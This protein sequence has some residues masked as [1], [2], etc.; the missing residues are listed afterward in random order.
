MD[1]TH[2]ASVIVVDVM[3]VDRV[4]LRSQEI[5]TIESRAAKASTN[6]SNRNRVNE[7][8]RGF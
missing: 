8:E 4:V 5:A 7:K 2:M 1:S 6:N 3:N